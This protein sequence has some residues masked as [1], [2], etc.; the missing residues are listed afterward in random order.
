MNVLF[1]THRLPYA[2]NRGDR[3]RAYYLLR[4]MARVAR[5]SVFSLVHSDREA[6]KV[7]TLPFAHDVAGA[8][9]TQFR[10]LVHGGAR[11]GSRRPLTHAL[12]DAPDVRQ[13]LGRLIHAWPPDVVVAYCS[14]MAR[15]AL[16]PPLDALP[17]VLDMVDVDS[18][19]WTELAA[20][21]R[22]PRRWIYEREAATLR[23]FEATATARARVTLVVNDRERQILVAIAPDARIAVVPNGVE[24][25]VFRSPEPPAADPRVIFCGVMDYAPNEEGVSWFAHQVWPKVRAARP[26]ARF[27]V[28]GSRPT[29]AV[30]ALPSHDASIEVVGGVPSVQPYLWRSSVA[31]APLRLA[32][33]IQNKVLEALAAGLPVVVTPAVCEGLPAEAMP[34]CTSALDPSE[35]AKSVVRLLDLTPAQRRQQAALADLSRLSWRERLAPV[36]AVLQQAAAKGTSGLTLAH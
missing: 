13:Q 34:G 24:M 35:F 20:R 32:R 33:G 17:L 10:N 16:E 22:G 9:V 4:E 21:A 27:I 6:S 2:P 7:Q 1:L 14:S 36:E 29:R 15:F 26:D 5:V 23:T 30:R 8:R 25:D 3:I 19:K 18:A 28:V 11:I 31:V 12:L